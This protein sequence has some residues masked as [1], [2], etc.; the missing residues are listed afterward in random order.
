MLSTY[1]NS[2]WVNSK[3]GVEVW[4]HIEKMNILNILTAKS[5]ANEADRV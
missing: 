5:I 2:V 1:Q 3:K 4:Y